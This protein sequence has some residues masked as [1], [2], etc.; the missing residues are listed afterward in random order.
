MAANFKNWKYFNDIFVL[1]IILFS[2]LD[3][4][5]EKIAFQNSS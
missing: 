5:L 3:S 4:Y 2:F 1:Y